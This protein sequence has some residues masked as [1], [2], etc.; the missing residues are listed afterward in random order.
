MKNDNRISPFT[1]R[2]QRWTD[3]FINLPVDR[4]NLFDR[5]LL[6]WLTLITIPDKDLAADERLAVAGTFISCGNRHPT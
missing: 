3:V 1:F 4:P 5:S 6:V 2:V